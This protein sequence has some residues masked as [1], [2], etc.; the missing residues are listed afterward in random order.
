MKLRDPH[1]SRALAVLLLFCVI[2]LPACARASLGNEASEGAKTASDSDIN[3]AAAGGGETTDASSSRSS[4]TEAREK[5]GAL[6]PENTAIPVARQV[7]EK[8]FDHRATSGNSRGDYTYIVDPGI[9]GEPDA[10]VFAAPFAGGEDSGDGAY[11]HNTGVWY[12][13]QKGKWAIFNQDRAEVSAGSGFRVVIPRDGKAFVHRASSENTTGN[14]TYVDDPLA[15]GRP[16]AGL[17]VAQNWNPG[18][19]AGVYNDHPV[20]VAYDTERG[21]WRISNT[22]GSKMP[23]GAAFNVTTSK[24]ARAAS[25]DAAGLGDDSGFPEYKDFYSKGDPKTPTDLV[26]G[27]PTV[28]AIP[29][30]QPFNFGRDPGGPED[31]TLYLTIPKLDLKDVPVFDTLSED[32][33]HDGTV[34]IPATGY[35]WQKGANV[36]IAGHRIGFPNT[37][38]YYVFFHLNWLEKGDEILLHDSTGRKFQYRVTDQKIVGPENVDVMNAVEGRSLIS[39]QTCTLPDYK[40]RLIVQGELVEMHA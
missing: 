25:T 37:D 10:I 4:E 2:F 9:N 40:E 39:L 38:S 31:R 35:P 36:F 5:T 30:V 16:D 26:S 19:G 22:D 14:S 21:K 8:A 34:H 24:A 23:E 7:E 15:N 1:G 33:L 13:P 28:G 18:G 6:E 20:D 29:P 32:R 27:T 3:R 12:E 17:S 11:H